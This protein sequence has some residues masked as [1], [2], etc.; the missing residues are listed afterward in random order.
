MFHI[1]N[2]VDD[3]FVSNKI[4]DYKIMISQLH[5]I[6]IFDKH[7]NILTFDLYKAKAFGKREVIL[8]YTQLNL[9]TYLQVVLYF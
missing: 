7:S 9:V 4:A 5:K 3:S 8:Y 2:D 6:H 1:K